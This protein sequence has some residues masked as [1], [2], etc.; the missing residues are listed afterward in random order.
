MKPVIW[1]N[2]AWEVTHRYTRQ[3]S[4]DHYLYIVLLSKVDGKD[5]GYALYVGETSKTPEE[6]FKQHKDGYKAS[7]YVERYGTK[8][9]F[10]I[11]N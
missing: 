9:A 7:R 6:R 4:G 1:I 11:S 5:P 3:T 8:P 10:P 2:K